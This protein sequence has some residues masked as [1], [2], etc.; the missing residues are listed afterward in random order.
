MTWVLFVLGII[1]FSIGIAFVRSAS[2]LDILV[3]VTFLIIGSGLF[4]GS[5][6]LGRRSGSKKKDE[7]K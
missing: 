1:A 5:G 7:L 6:R 3:S 2:P 4:L